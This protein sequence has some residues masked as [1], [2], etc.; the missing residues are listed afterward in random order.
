V[1]AAYEH[2]DRSVLLSFSCSSLASGSFWLQK[3]LSTAGA[4]VSSCGPVVT[5][6]RTGKSAGGSSSEELSRTSHL[7]AQCGS[8]YHRVPVFYNASAM[9]KTSNSL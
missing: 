1:S 2:V 5:H 3:C 8:L 6:P 7:K 9:F 4:V